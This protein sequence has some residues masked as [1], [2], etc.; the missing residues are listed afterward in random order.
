[1]QEEY[2]PSAASLHLRV[3]YRVQNVACQCLLLLSRVCIE[4]RKW[5]GT[6]FSYVYMETIMMKIMITITGIILIVFKYQLYR[7]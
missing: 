1:M 7:N 4:C 5:K 2:A 3:I 6:R